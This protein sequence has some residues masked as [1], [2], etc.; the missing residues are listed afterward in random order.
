M[1]PFTYDRIEN[2]KNGLYPLL[3][4][5]GSMENM[6]DVLEEVRFNNPEEATV[7]ILPGCNHGNGMYKQTEMYQSAIKTFLEEHCNV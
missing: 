7:L 5:A 4:S 1:D 6:E 2:S 3:L